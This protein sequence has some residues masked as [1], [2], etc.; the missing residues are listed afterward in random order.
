MSEFYEE[1]FVLIEKKDRN[2]YIERCW[3]SANPQKSAVANIALNDNALL[4]S[5]TALARSIGRNRPGVECFHR[6]IEIGK[7]WNLRNSRAC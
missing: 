1:E 4:T 7:K 5:V 3:Y 2:K 6:E